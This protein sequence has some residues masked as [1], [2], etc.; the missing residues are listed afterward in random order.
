MEKLLYLTMQEIINTRVDVS[1]VKKF[2]CVWPG[3]V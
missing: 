2:R 1:A 3:F